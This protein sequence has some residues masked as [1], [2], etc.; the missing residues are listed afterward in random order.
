MKYEIKTN[1]HGQIYIPA[2]VRKQVLNGEKELELHPNNNIGIIMP[3][4]KKAEEVLKS[5]KT[6]QSHFK[7]LKEDSNNGSEKW[8]DKTI[9][10]TSTSSGESFI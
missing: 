9:V 8:G 2:P 10:Q 7:E 6:L 4:G 3:K 1:P 5:L